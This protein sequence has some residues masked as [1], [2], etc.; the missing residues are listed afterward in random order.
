MFLSGAKVKGGLVEH[1]HKV[2]QTRYIHFIL[3][4]L[5]TQGKKERGR[6]KEGKREDERGRE[7]EGKQ[8]WGPNGL[9]TNR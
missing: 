7:E 8:D 6:R 3:H 9:K 1:L 2:L 4:R 5:G